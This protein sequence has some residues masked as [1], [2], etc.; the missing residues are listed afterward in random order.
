[1]TA[2]GLLL[3]AC[4]VAAFAAFARPAAADDTLSVVLGT[5]LP[6]LMDTLDLVAEGAG[7]YRA[8]HLTVTKVFVPGAAEAV[9]ACAS[10]KADVCPIDIER[11][12]SDYEGGRHVQLFLARVARYT[13]IMAVPAD[14]PIR[15]LADFKGT[16]VGVHQLGV[17]NRPFG[18]QV[19]VATTLGSAGLKTGDYTFQAI[20]FNAQAV[21]AITSGRVAGA[22]LPRYELLPFEVA[23]AKL[24]LFTNPVLG[25]VVS[26]GYGAAPATIQA[27]GDALRRFARAIVKAALFVRWNPAASARLVLQ[28]NGQPYTDDDVR[29][30]AGQLTL[31]ED[32]LLARDPSSKQIGYI[33]PAGEE[34]YRKLLIQYGQIA[35]TVT[36]P[37]IVTN[38]FNAFANDFDHR[39]LEAFAKAAR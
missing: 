19:A 17:D 36:I 34:L 5:G 7:F 1:L 12:F 23:G 39:A 9:D 14:G 27:K 37:D 10:G 33:S 15:T 22:G 26:A 6:P 18:G 35:G 2:R 25:D 28:V 24:R 16:A 21:A 29:L 11:V 38:Q 3:G 13:Y 32:D 31:W 30:Y 20:G 8:E 4:A